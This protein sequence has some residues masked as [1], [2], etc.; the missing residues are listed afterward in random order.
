VSHTLDGAA[1]TNYLSHLLAGMKIVDAR[2][3]DPTTNKPLFLNT[4]FQS[5]EL[6]FPFKILFASDS[7]DA[8]H[9]AM[10]DFF[11]FFKHL[12]NGLPESEF[13]PAFRPFKVISP[14]DMAAHW[15]SLCVGG[16]SHST[17]FFARVAW[18]IVTVKAYLLATRSATTVARNGI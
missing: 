4:N 11:S 16:G 1:L 12:K 5:R 3:T 15:K 9:V 8:Y 14:Q 6:C 18:C 10:S 13:G 2:A 7:D 17:N